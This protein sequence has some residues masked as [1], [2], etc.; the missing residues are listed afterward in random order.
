M[1]VCAAREGLLSYNRDAGIWKQRKAQVATD[2][3]LAGWSTDS[4]R[5]ATSRRGILASVSVGL[6][7]I[8][9]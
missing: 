7:F 9:I 6:V 3:Q 4:K 8:A 5:R 1:T 2:R